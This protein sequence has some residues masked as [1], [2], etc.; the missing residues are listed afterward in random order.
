MA[1]SDV[2]YYDNGN[3]SPLYSNWDQEMHDHLLPL[4]HYILEQA[5]LSGRY[6]S[7]LLIELGMTFN[8]TSNL[9]LS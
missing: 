9:S 3:I 8:L 5:K 4:Q 7:G 6:N 2:E 1:H